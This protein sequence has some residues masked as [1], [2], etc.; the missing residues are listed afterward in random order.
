MFPINFPPI[1]N[2]PPLNFPPTSVPIPNASMVDPDKETGLPRDLWW[3]I[4]GLP[5]TPDLTPA[6]Q[7]T[8]ADPAWLLCRQWQF[9]EFAGDDAGTPIQV[10][11]QGEVSPLSR[12]A[13]GV[14][15]PATPYTPR[16]YSTDA[17]PLETAVEREP[18]WSRHP[19]IVAEAGQHLIRM[20]V[21]AG[22]APVR[23]AVLASF[24]LTLPPALDAG[25]DTAGD[26]WRQLAQSRVI[27][28]AK[29]AAAILTARGTAPTLTTLPAGLSVDA[30]S[31]PKTLD[32]LTRWLAWFQSAVV[33]PDGAESWS[34]RRLEYSFAVG[35]ASSAGEVV[36]DAQSYADGNLDW[37]SVTGAGQTL[38]TPPATPT[39]LTVPP[40]LPTPV[41][42]AGKPADRFWEFEDTNVSFGII[43]A[44]PTDLARMALI[45]FSL[46]YGNDWF[47][48]PLTL[49]VGSVFHATTFTVRDTFGVDTI[50]GPSKNTGATAWSV[51]SLAGGHVPDGAF[52][53]APTL[54]D[55]LE[56]APLEEVA[57]FRDEMA[58]MVWG[59]ERTVQ[60]ISGDPY[61]RTND[62]YQRAAQQQ[63]SGPPVDAQLV[64]RLA[65]SVPDN[66]IPFVPGPAEGS[67]PG[68]NPV[69]QLQR[70]AMVRVE[71]DGSRVTVQP[72]GVL[73]R[74][75]PTK[76]AATEP[77]LRIEEEEVPRE[78]AVVTRTFQFARWFDGRS[79]LWAGK[80][81]RPGRGEG[82]SGL[83]FDVSDKA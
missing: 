71:I 10:S 57:L 26:E 6:L 19:R 4:E 66:W 67:N 18:V 24:P 74:S 29:L 9:L 31:R 23:D 2:I 54:I 27:D 53:L 28:A 81:K 73:L 20:L 7:A 13:P 61:D 21:A 65:S 55:T 83:R 44:G 37:Y 30:A 77:S 70:R 49:P 62:E 48:V 3:R 58:N 33:E 78:G 45:E 60:G 15:T 32:V 35:G 75:D 52:F 41:E 69:I 38:G 16:D 12:F 72:R 80:R 34:P 82:S 42:Y 59:V 25:S 1:I 50:I 68:T 11:V 46:I 43:D 63:V 79:L 17:L 14:A 39:M 22:V 56:S 47:V 36:L 40:S 76:T 8:I 64:Y 5:L 51:F